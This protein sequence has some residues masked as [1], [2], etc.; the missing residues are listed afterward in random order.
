VLTERT[1][2][3][4]RCRAVVGPANNQLAS[5][6]AADLLHR[7]GILWVPDY[8]AGAGGVIHA[9]TTELHRLGP[10]EARARIAA[11]ED[12]VTGL[13][14]TAARLGRT[15]AEAADAL[16]RRRVRTAAP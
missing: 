13:L 9:V 16:A 4:L 8:V 2:P 12:T 11:I 1:V 6:D 7:R 10:G 3:R 15:P 5:P 14:D